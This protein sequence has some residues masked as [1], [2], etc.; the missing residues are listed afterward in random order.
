MSTRRMSA[1]GGIAEGLTCST[2]ICLPDPA[3]MSRRPA[4]S[5]VV[6]T[7]RKYRCGGGATGKG[8]LELPQARPRDSRHQAVAAVMPSVEAMT[9]II[10]FASAS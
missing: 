1:P 8:L 2:S 10:F 5:I 6:R 3:A 9:S 7:P 4:L